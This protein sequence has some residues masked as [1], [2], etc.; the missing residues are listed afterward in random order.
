MRIGPN[1]FYSLE[2]SRNHYL[3]AIEAHP[4]LAVVASL[5]F[6]VMFA[7]RTPIHRNLLRELGYSLGLG[8]TTTYAYPFYYYQQYLAKVDECFDVVTGEFKR[9]PKLIEK[10]R[11]DEDKNPSILKNFGLSQ[12]ADEDIVG[13]EDGT[14]ENT[15]NIFANGSEEEMRKDNMRKFIEKL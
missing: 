1:I 10:L 2:R 3:Q 12:S 14:A 4:A 13:D 5:G 8:F 7:I 9:R 15:T 6:F 11:I